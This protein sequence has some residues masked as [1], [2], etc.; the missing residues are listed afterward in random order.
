VDGGTHAQRRREVH[1]PWWALLAFVASG[2]EHSIANMTTFSL[3]AL[4][5]SGTWSMLW[6]NLAWTVPGNVVGGTL[7]VGGSYAWLGSKARPPD[8]A[9]VPTAEPS[10]NGQ[11]QELEPASAM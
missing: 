3:A 1:R 11:E 4:G 5:G 10:S 6:H 9:M 8:E 7:V 2:F